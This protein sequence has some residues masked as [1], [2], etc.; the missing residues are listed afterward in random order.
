[1]FQIIKKNLI[2]KLQTP[3]YI[4]ISKIGYK[5]LRLPAKCKTKAYNKVPLAK[6]RTNSLNM[7]KYIFVT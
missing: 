5:K 2:K 6:A 7:Y 3:C 1:M 4:N